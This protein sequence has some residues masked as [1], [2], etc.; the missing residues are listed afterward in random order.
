MVASYGL[1]KANVGKTIR[2]VVEALLASGSFSLPSKRKLVQSNTDIEVIV[3]DTTEVPVQR[4]QCPK[5]Q[6][7]Y[8]FGCI[9]EQQAFFDCD[10]GR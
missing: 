8:Y 4:P 7:A 1:T 5:K 9:P 3:I 6:K 10:Q 2:W